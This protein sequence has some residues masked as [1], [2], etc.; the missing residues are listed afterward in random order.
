MRRGLVHIR[1]E[2]LDRLVD[3]MCVWS[4]VFP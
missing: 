1:K 2:C 4:S 3:G